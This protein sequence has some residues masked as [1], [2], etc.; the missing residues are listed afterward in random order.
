MYCSHYFG[1]FLI[2]LILG[3]CIWVIFPDFLFLHL[4]L[5]SLRKIHVMA[6]NF[7]HVKM[8]LDSSK[9]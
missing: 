9:L 8:V 3:Q 2:L 4:T 7:V 1:H 5:S 6:I